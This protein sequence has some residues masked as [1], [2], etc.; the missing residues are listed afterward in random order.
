MACKPGVWLALSVTVA[1]Q[2]QSPWLATW[3]SL[4]VVQAGEVTEAEVHTGRAPCAQE[5]RCWRQGCGGQSIQ[6]L[7]AGAVAPVPLATGRWKVLLR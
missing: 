6:E 4:H 2:T 1:N 3:G 7:R 5:G